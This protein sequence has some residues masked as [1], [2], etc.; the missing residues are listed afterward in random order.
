L[1]SNLD[2]APAGSCDFFNI[3]A[4]KRRPAGYKRGNQATEKSESCLVARRPGS[5]DL[6]NIQVP[7]AGILLPSSPAHPVERSCY[8]AWRHNNVS[9]DGIECIQ[10]QRLILFYRKDVAAFLFQDLI[11][12]G[13]LKADAL[14]I[15]MKRLADG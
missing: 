12:E 13:R 4:T 2:F 5:V 11:G 3:Q 1:G 14:R 15:S 7:L 8:T 6:A 10:Q 9:S